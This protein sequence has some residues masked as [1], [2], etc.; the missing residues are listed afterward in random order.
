MKFHN[1]K[2]QE[3]ENWKGTGHRPS[4]N[5]MKKDKKGKGQYTNR[6]SRLKSKRGNSQQ[7]SGLA[8]KLKTGKEH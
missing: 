2:P 5:R 3:K 6:L 7:K 8:K 4:R 1:E